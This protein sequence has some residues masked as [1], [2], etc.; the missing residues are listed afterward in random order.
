MDY[1]VVE[2]PSFKVV[3]KAMRVTTK[4]GENLRR[5]PEFWLEC[6]RDGS[7]DKIEALGAKGVVLGPVTL[8]ICL[9]FSSNMEEFT[10]MIAAE[11]SDGSV[12]DG[13]IEREIPAAT[14][15]AFEGK[16]AMPDSIQTVWGGI[17]SDF[18]PSGQYKHGNAPDLE[19]YPPGDPRDADYRFEVWVPVIAG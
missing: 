19:L 13:L 18:F 2:K 3:G 5:I 1:R 16:G 17:W 8:G 11:S 9:D 12:P 7:H 6:L 4:D 15:A 14:W 10:Y